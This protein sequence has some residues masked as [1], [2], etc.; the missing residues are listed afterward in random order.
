MAVES[1]LSRSANAS[2]R[3]RRTPLLTPAEFGQ[4]YHFAQTNRALTLTMRRWAG[5]ADGQLHVRKLHP[6]NARRSDKQIPA[7]GDAV[8]HVREF[9]GGKERTLGAGLIAQTWTL[10]DGSSRRSL[11]IVLNAMHRRPEFTRDNVQR[12]RLA[13]HLLRVKPR[14]AVH[15][16][17]KIQKP[18]GAG[19]SQQSKHPGGGSMG[20]LARHQRLVR[21]NKW[22]HSPRSLRTEIP[23]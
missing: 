12:N 16:R 13:A 8:L 10:V 9:A 20:R 15:A 1:G 2:A 5:M 11:Y 3:S 17:G 19:R 23:R 7:V 14:D 6:A 4:E 22:R 18:Q 21:S